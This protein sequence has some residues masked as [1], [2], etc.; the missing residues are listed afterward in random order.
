MIS[1]KISIWS[2]EHW[3]VN[4]I[5]EF[6]STGGKDAIRAKSNTWVYILQGISSSCISKAVL[7]AWESSHCETLTV[8]PLE[9]RKRP[10]RNGENCGLGVLG[11]EHWHCLLHHPR[12]LIFILLWLRASYQNVH[13]CSNSFWISDL[14]PGKS[15]NVDSLACF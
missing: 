1:G 7:I 15:Q 12:V 10:H 6:S 9:V 4:Y 2:R 8:Q 5:S 11:R 13:Q 14:H 3:S